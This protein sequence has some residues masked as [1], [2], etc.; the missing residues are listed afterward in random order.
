MDDSD[1]VRSFANEI[2]RI[3]DNLK[4]AGRILDSSDKKFALLKGLRSAYTVK[5]TILQDK[6]DILL[7]KVVSSLH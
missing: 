4:Y 3:E 6:T 7:E 2:C 5:M 1:T